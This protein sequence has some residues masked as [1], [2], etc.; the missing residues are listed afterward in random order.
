[1]AKYYFSSE[2]LINS[3]KRRASLPDSQDCMSPE[4]ILDIANE[5]MQINLIPMILSKHEDYYLVRQEIPL[6]ANQLSYPMPYRAIGSKLRE[7]AYMPNPDYPRD[8]REMFRISADDVVHGNVGGSHRHYYFEQENLVLFG[9]SEEVPTG[10]IVLFY[11]LRPNSLVLSDKVSLINSVNFTTGEIVVDNMPSEFSISQEFDF[12][13]KRSPHRILSFDNRV[14]NI[15]L[16]SK[17]ITLDPS[18]IPT[19][20]TAGDRICLA[21]ETD[22]INCP[23]ELHSVLAQMVATKV[24]ESIGDLT[25]LEAASNKLERMQMNTGDLIDN[26]VDGSPFK[27]RVRNGFLSR[28]RSRNRR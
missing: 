5:E 27:V 13:Q 19:T 15:N 6:V 23:S 21:G 16:T 18:V 20:L 14:L 10:K 24:L 28:S 1:M 8:L 9:S 2:D 11:F 12:I 7:V 17:T 22:L 4:D 3:V 26:R 25:N